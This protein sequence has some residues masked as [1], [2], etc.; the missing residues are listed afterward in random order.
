[1]KIEL[2]SPSLASLSVHLIEIGSNSDE[3][4]AI[5]SILMN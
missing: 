3:A 5:H 2:G 1:M 4:D